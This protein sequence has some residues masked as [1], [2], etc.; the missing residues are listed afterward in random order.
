MICVRVRVCQLCLCLFTCLCSVV[1]TKDAGQWVVPCIGVYLSSESTADITAV[2]AL[3][4]TGRA[5]KVMFCVWVVG[6]LDTG[7][8]PHQTLRP[9]DT[10]TPTHN[11]PHPPTTTHK[12][13]ITDHE[14]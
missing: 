14:I 1:D 11:H 6:M 4:G 12:T 9:A 8:F 5:P 3:L 2:A 13:K 7:S 10:G